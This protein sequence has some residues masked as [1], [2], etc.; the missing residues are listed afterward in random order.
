MGKELILD[1]PVEVDNV[2][3]ITRIVSC[4]YGF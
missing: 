2:V 3:T 1:K 4:I